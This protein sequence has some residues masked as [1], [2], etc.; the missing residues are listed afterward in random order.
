MHIAPHGKDCAPCRVTKREWTTWRHAHTVHTYGNSVL[1]STSFVSP[2]SLASGAPR[3]EAVAAGVAGT[4]AVAVA[5]GS[6]VGG[7]PPGCFRVGGYSCVFPYP[8]SAGAA[9]MGTWVAGRHWLCN[10]CTQML[11]RLHVVLAATAS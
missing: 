6:R 5:M 1:C 7:T 2:H 3:M 11:D 8:L 9:A 4:A 10:M